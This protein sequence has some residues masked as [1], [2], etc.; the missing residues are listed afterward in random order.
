MTPLSKQLSGLIL[1]HDYY[2]NHLNSNGKTINNDLE[3]KNFKFAGE[4]LCEVFSNVIIDSYETVAEFIN[5]DSSELES[6]NL[7]HKSESWIAQHV[8][9]TQ[10]MTQIVKCLDKNCCGTIRSKF[11]KIIKSR[12]LPAPI[13][14]HY[15]PMIEM[16]SMDI[17][18]LKCTSLFQNLHF[19]SPES[20]YDQYCSSVNDKVQSRTCK[21]C[22]IYFASLTL[23]S[24]HKKFTPEK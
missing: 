21:K 5:R 7:I 2:G 12:F 3:Y 11:H 4:A 17:N 13:P 19:A 23:L 20:P 18:K 9:S 15:A 1:P 6:T 14:L 10:Y 24:N 8:R 16:E 22:K